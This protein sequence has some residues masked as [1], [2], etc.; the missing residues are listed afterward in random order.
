[1]RRVILVLALAIVLV[2]GVVVSTSDISIQAQGG[3][4]GVPGTP[5][6]CLDFS[7]TPAA[8]MASPSLALASTPIASPEGSPMACPSDVTVGTPAP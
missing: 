8:P 4:S 6:L 5:T 2:S 7:A 1:M 3:D